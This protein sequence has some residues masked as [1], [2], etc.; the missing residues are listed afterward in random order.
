[1]Y[2]LLVEDEWGLLQATIFWPVYERYGEL[3]HHEGAFL[4]E[5]VI[6]QDADRGFSFLIRRMESL[7]EVLADAR[8]P[9]PKAAT[10][11]GA[12][13]RAGRRS[14]RA[15]STAGDLVAQSRSGSASP[16]QKPRGRGDTLADNIWR[17]L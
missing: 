12:F 1:V 8:A 11:S 2:F 15:G 14:R 7:R 17:G 13:L 6:E 4:L 3:L 5:G 9:A 10:T 16:P